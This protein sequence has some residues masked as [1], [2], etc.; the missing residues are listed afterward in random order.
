MLPDKVD[1]RGARDAALILAVDALPAERSR[2]RLAQGAIALGG[3]AAL[4]GACSALLAPE[5]GPAA[6]WAAG[7]LAILGIGVALRVGTRLVCEQIRLHA[8]QELAWTARLWAHEAN[9]EMPAGKKVGAERALAE[10][11]GFDPGGSWPLSW[12]ARLAL[13]GTGNRAW[14]GGEA[15]RSGHF[16]ELAAKI[17]GSKQGPKA[18]RG[19]EPSKE[20][21][22]RAE[23]FA[24]LTLAGR[25]FQDQA[26]QVEAETP[27]ARAGR[28]PVRI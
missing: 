20:A 1:W 19:I 7:G 26:K 6:Q 5:L 8:R 21:L 27:T 24:R 13:E 28:G 22:E 2:R 15:S 10:A 11:A 9:D 3:A 17:A 25:F 12:G 16:A 4:A 23:A 14:P 18:A